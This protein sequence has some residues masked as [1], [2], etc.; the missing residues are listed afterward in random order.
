M[1]LQTNPDK[2]LEKADPIFSLKLPCGGAD[3]LP[4]FLCGAPCSQP[5][6][7]AHL[8]PGLKPV[9]E[10]PTLPSALKVSEEE[11]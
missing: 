1:I 11:S 7:V 10:W 4:R 8:P 6:E 5:L 9:A 3:S 2:G